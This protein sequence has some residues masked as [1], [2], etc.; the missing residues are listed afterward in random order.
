MMWTIGS[1][2]GTFEI[3]RKVEAPDRESALQECGIM[4][5]LLQAGWHFDESPEGE[6]HT[7]ELQPTVMVTKEQRDTLRHIKKI[8]DCNTSLDGWDICIL[9]EVQEYLA[10][11][12]IEV[13][14]SAWMDE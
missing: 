14:E 10:M 13:S 12:G 7:A 8:F 2:Y 1:N 6:L 9:E 3:W 5:T 4:E 11:R